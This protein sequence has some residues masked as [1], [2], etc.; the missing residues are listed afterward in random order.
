MAESNVIITVPSLVIWP[1]VSP[2]VAK[3]TKELLGDSRGAAYTVEL[4]HNTGLYEPKP[5]F[6]WGQ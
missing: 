5:H 2:E 4:N 3:A 6:G 1:D